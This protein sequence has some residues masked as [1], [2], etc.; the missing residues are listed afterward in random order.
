VIRLL[1][2]VLVL[3]V[4]VNARAQVKAPQEYAAILS[5]VKAKFWNIDP[6]IGY[7]V[8]N[9][10][11]GVYVISDN[12]WQ[13]AWLVTNEGVIVIDAP[14][15]FGKNI[16]AEVTQVTD[17]PIKMLIYS[18]Q[19]RDHIGGSP[20][21]KD[22]KGLQIVA[23]D[24]VAKYLREQNDPERLIPNV[25]FTSQKTIK[26]G[27]K[28]VALTAH[29]YHSEEGDLFYMGTRSQVLDGRGLCDAGIH[30]VSGIRLDDEFR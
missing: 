5:S 29:Y 9:V 3:A 2:A 22:I 7:A 4:F 18:H 1:P 16:P 25:T 17:K 12:G 13:S 20:A 24:S 26:L 23:L 28:T 6:K 8:K 15:T 14:E 30:S 19:H 11:N 21:F 27:G 10:G